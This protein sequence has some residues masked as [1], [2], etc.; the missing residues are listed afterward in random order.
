MEKAASA[1]KAILVPTDRRVNSIRHQIPFISGHP[2]MVIP[3]FIPCNLFSRVIR[4]TVRQNGFI[5]KTSRADTQTLP[6][7][8]TQATQTAM[9]RTSI[10]HWPYH[11]LLVAV[12]IAPV[13]HPDGRFQADILAAFFEG[14][15]SQTSSVLS[16]GIRLDLEQKSTESSCLVTKSSNSEGLVELALREWCERILERFRMVDLFV[17]SE[18]SRTWNSCAK[19]P[20]F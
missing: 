9:T 4:L 6:D 7:F 13:A 20:E 15:H 3:S 18:Q 10:N 1:S 12:V 14:T 19:D 16:T 5:Q 11:M 17:V 2:I 8:A